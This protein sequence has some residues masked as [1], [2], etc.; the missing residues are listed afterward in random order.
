MGTLNVETPGVVLR[1]VLPDPMRLPETDLLADAV[2]D[3]A[4]HILATADPSRKDRLWPTDPMGYQTNPLNLAHGA[5]GTSIFLHEALG[6][7]PAEVRDWLLGQP[8]DIAT[9]PPGLYPGIAGVAWSF[10]EMGMLER[11]L[12]LFELVPK[13]PLA[14]QCAC[15]FSGASGWG[16][17][18][19]ALHRKTGDETLLAL[20]C[21]AGNYLNA[22]RELGEKGVCWRNG[23]DGRVYLGFA[24]GSSGAALFL[25]RLWQATGEGRYLDLARAA[26]EFDIAHAQ[27]RKST[28]RWGASPEDLGHSPYWLR[29]GAGV[30]ATLIRFFEALGEERYLDLARRG[31]RGCASFFSAAPHLF[32]GLAAMGDTMLDMFLLT[33]DEDYLEL[34]R[35]KARQTLLYRIERPEGMAFPGRYLLRLSHD[36]GVGSAGIGHFLYRLAGLRPRLFHDFSEK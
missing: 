25:L 22:T 8:V 15:L 12:E 10:A 5:V 13:S 31:A 21:Q 4:R 28:L 30:T 33:G 26:L 2:R 35:Q 9:Y 17:A 24:L 29:G 19:L 34:S 1:P 27:D 23:T 7:L 6:E 36:Y 20:A 16:L 14:F 3:I 32:E 18:A 11:G